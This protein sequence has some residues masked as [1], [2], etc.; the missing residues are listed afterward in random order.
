MNCLFNRMICRFHLNFQWWFQGLPVFVRQSKAEV[1]RRKDWQGSDTPET[2]G[3]MKGQEWCM[4]TE[5]DV[6]LES[7]A[8]ETFHQIL[9][10][11]P[12][13]FTRDPWKNTTNFSKNIKNFWIIS[14]VDQLGLQYIFKAYVRCLMVEKQIFAPKK[15]ENK[16]LLGMAGAW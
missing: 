8:V 5:F 15:K 7:T 11:R 14:I 1:E 16:A 4:S 2:G 10:S 3:S 9:L 6:L 12:T 13:I